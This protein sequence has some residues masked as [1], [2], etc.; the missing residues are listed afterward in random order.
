MKQRSSAGKILLT[1]IIVIAVLLL[2]AEFGLRWFIG[3]QVVQ[4]LATQDTQTS[5]EQKEK[6]KISFG[7]S[8]L[9]LGLVKGENPLQIR[10]QIRRI[11]LTCPIL[12]RHG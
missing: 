12:L 2:L 4:A 10:L 9:L 8:P 5:S 3:N 11:R 7:T 6:P 1:I